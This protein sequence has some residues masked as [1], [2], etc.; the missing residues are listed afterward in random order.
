MLSIKHPIFEKPLFCW[1]PRLDGRGVGNATLIGIISVVVLFDII[2]VVIQGSIGVHVELD[3]VRR[4]GEEM[5]SGVGALWTMK[6]ESF[7]IV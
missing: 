7:E 6:D 5:L 4:I 3:K 1:T 2:D